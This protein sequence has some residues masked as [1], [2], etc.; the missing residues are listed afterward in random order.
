MKQF[1]NE[2]GITMISLVITIIIL[3]I[4]SSMIT[5]T[6]IDSIKNSKF[7]RLKKELEIMQSNVNVWYEKY[8]DMPYSEITAIGIMVPESKSDILRR[9]LEEI[10]EN[11]MDIDT[12]I[13][14]YRYFGKNEFEDLQISGVENDYIVDVKSQ[15]AI[16]VD[17]YEYDG[18]KYYVLDQVRDVVRG[19]ENDTSCIQKENVKIR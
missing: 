2:K 13:S 4:L 3:I 7:E 10:K 15:I 16:L 1:S 12:D 14:K 17:G 8:C 6:G 18:K 9:Q 19:K 5:R 11:I